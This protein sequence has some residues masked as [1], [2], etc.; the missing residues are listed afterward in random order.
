MET[1]NT[2]KKSTTNKIAFNLDGN[3]EVSVKGFIAPIEKPY[4][5]FMSNGMHWRIYASLNQKNAIQYLFSEHF[6]RTSLFR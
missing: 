6:F 5:I 1:L 3:A 4:P 2:Y